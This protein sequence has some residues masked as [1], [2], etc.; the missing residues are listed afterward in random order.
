MALTLG[1]APGEATHWI[2]MMS[3]K[4][5]DIRCC[6]GLARRLDQ[7]RAARACPVISPVSSSTSISKSNRSAIPIPPHDAVETYHPERIEAQSITSAAG[8]A[9][10]RTAGRGLGLVVV[11]CVPITSLAGCVLLGSIRHAEGS[12][13]NPF[14]GQG[15][16]VSENKSLHKKYCGEEPTE[17]RSAGSSAAVG[18]ITDQCSAA[19]RGRRGRSSRLP[20]LCGSQ[21]CYRRLGLLPP[22]ACPRFSKYFKPTRETISSRTSLR[23][24]FNSFSRRLR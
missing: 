23:W 16:S 4:A 8:P 15:T 13:C 20:Y 3:A 5:V 18:S 6:P 11:A 19:V 24:C 10:S 9:K 14:N 1:G 17:A 22:R 12:D 21:L 7:P 2:A